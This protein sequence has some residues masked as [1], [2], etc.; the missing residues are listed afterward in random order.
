MQTKGY[1]ENLI[2]RYKTVLNKCRLMNTFG[3][4][5]AAAMLTLG[6]AG[7][8]L[9]TDAYQEPPAS[10]H[11]TIDEPNHRWYYDVAREQNVLV[12][13]KNAATEAESPMAVTGSAGITRFNY[14]NIW[15]MDGYAQGMGGTP[16]ENHT[17]LN[18]GNIY[19][20]ETMPGAGKGMGVDSGG[21][22]LNV[23]IIAVRRGSG[24][25]DNSGSA[26]KTMVNS[27]VI[28]AEGADSVGMHY[29]RQAVGGEV[30]NSGTI[31]AGNGG[32]GV[33]VTSEG[34]GAEGDNKVFL[35]TG[36]IE[37]DRNS[38]AVLVTGT[39]GATVKLADE[40]RV[41]GL[42]RLQGTNNRLSVVGVGAEGRENL[43]VQGAFSGS[44][45]GSRV[46]FTDDSDIRLDNGFIIDKE[47]EVSLSGV[48]LV[49]G[50]R[51][52]AE[53]SIVLDKGN[54]TLNGGLAEGSG[55][56]G[57]LSADKGRIV[58]DRAELSGNRSQADPKSPVA[59]AIAAVM[60]EGRSLAVRNS[61]FD[62]NRTEA[63]VSSGHG[64]GALS[65][66]G[67]GGPVRVEESVFKGN[68]GV[69]GGALYNGGS[70]VT[71][72]NSTFADNTAAAAGGALYNAE[73][74]T[75][76]F[77]GTNVFTG[78]LAAGTAG[79]IHNRGTMVVA[80]GRTLLNGGYTQEG[81][82]S[83]LSVRRG[84]A[85]SIAMPDAGGVSAGAGTALLALDAPLELG[86]GTLTVGTVTARNNA[87]AAFG[88]DSV[89]VLNGRAASE[90]AMIRSADGG[91][92]AV[93]KDAALY[94]TDAQAGKTY[95]VT[96]GL[97]AAEGEYWAGADLLGS[98]L[99][100]AD[101]RRDGEKITVV[102]EMKDAAQALPG[103][104]P[105]R[106]MN[107][108]ISG[109][110]NDT[111]ASSMGIRFLSR[112]T[113]PGFLASDSLAVATVNEVSRAAVTA[114]VQNTA[115]R[116][117]GAGAEQIA[118]QL[119]LSFSPGDNSMTQDGLN[120]WAAPMY[121]NTRT[122]GMAVSG[123]SVRGNYGGLALGA[124][125]K[126]GEILGGSVRVGASVHGGGGKSDTRGTAT[127]TTNSYNFGGVSLYAGWN[128]DNLN[129]VG[130]AGYAAADH[131][132]KMNLPASLGM[133]RADA[134]VNTDAFLAEL[135]AE[136]LISTPVADILP[137]AG[138]RYTALYTESHNVTVGGRLLNRAGAD[139]QHIVEFP[140]GVTAAKSFDIAGWNM[141][142][143][144]D[145]SVIP[146]AG[147][148]KNTTKVS[149]AGINAVDGVSTRIMDSTSFS[150]MVGLQAEKGS[151]AL[152]LNYGVQAS[153]H[154]TD[155]R[156][157]MGVSWK[158]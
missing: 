44:V 157:N 26:D 87:A 88:S 100:R 143:Q 29:R 70:D 37:A 142:P 121:G 74:G 144:A 66:T 115:L 81:A 114:G 4:L 20:G 152:G 38:T 27:G 136:Y 36:T 32:T 72:Q 42:I 25:A 62:D 158:F 40:S 77:S 21:T 53:G 89:L 61:T 50:P 106:A 146:A 64:G 108:M 82:S 58:I 15:V 107:A 113:E 54:L 18:Q 24:M 23:G 96:E 105:A 133:G 22:A 95:T 99:T 122:H 134:N 35:N 141:R 10:F 34:V 83:G 67:R 16:G 55:S 110:R 48:R 147:D 5:A 2:N 156:V 28:T 116:L 13:G 102:A 86:S 65:V 93:E 91:S 131:D 94:I 97:S 103:V 84:A 19:V 104:I 6:G 129:I 132:V 120:V 124:D 135:R 98:R 52:N 125:T 148:R 56:L 78:N 60:E 79:D 151:L 33:L 126:A 75:L 39:D 12:S 112:A 49:R 31:Q 3:S 7:A 92:L 118:R 127:S 57:S 138:V 76:T 41:D 128:I 90:S 68:A 153:R 123:A 8:A 154:E 101:I 80:E 85:L 11:T 130:S 14:G 45:E 69:F 30:S 17:I 155:Q 47:S 137:H 119:S 71:I 117:A 111:E 109:N 145:V 1:I 9:A 46:A 63:D 150:G 59:G 73:G 139:T 43:Q 140:V 149:Y 51:K